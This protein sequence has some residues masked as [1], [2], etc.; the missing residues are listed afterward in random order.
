MA[1]ESGGPVP[2]Q[3]RFG[4]PIDQIAKDHEIQWLLDEVVGAAFERCLR[5]RHVPMGGDQDGLGIWLMF[6]N[7]CQDF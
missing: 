3:H 1:L 5:G 4:R 2:K 7:K 6:L